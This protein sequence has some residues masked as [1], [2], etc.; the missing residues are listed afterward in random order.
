MAESSFALTQDDLFGLS[1]AQRVAPEF[2]VFISVSG[3]SK[4]PYLNL[5]MPR[6]E[7]YYGYAQIMAGAYVVQT[8]QLQYVN[9]RVYYDY[10]DTS[11][12]YDAIGCAVQALGGGTAEITPRRRDITAIRVKSAPWAE[13][14]MTVRWI[15]LYS[16]CGNLYNDPVP[17]QGQPPEPKND[18][19]DP[20]DQP[21]ENRLD[22]FDNTGAD[23][24]D[25][26][27]PKP[28]NNDLQGVWTWT[29]LYSPPFDAEFDSTAPG[30]DTDVPGTIP[31]PPY[32]GS[33][34]DRVGFTLNGV[35]VAETDNVDSSVL[36][37]SEPVF[38]R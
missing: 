33:S 17:D 6:N 26:N 16:L 37:V 11:L 12:I 28:G 19:Q 32:S 21:L 35:L 4:E 18:R 25:P 9:Q 23:G 27:A 10:L 20:N 22:P 1:D 24:Q 7:S 15:P 29:V 8:V 13:L 30:F 36:S 2:A 38:S 3:L 5:K 31:L 14:N 34:N